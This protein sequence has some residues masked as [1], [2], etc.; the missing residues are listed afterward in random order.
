MNENSLKDNILVKKVVAISK[1]KDLFVD[2]KNEINHFFSY[3][4]KNP[5]TVLKQ[6]DMFQELLFSKYF[7]KTADKVEM[8]HTYLDMIVENPSMYNIEDK[9]LMEFED[10]GIIDL[11][12]EEL[13]LVLEVLGYDFLD[14]ANTVMVEKNVLNSI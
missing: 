14:D 13:N 4:P 5:S 2:L 1:N 6:L 11:F 8:L 10:S 12:N 3:P 9:I 7:Y